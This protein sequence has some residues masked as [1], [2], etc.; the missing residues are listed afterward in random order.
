M[1][2]FAGQIRF[3]IDDIGIHRIKRK[4]LDKPEV[5]SWVKEEVA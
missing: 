3:V 5:V 1:K 2:V 4:I